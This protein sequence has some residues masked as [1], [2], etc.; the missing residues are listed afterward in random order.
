MGCYAIGIGG[1]GARGVEALVHLCAAGLGPSKLFVLIV[2]PDQANGNVDRAKQVISRYTICREQLRQTRGPNGTNLF[3]TEIKYG[4]RDGQPILAWS[5]TFAEKT[6]SDYFRYNLLPPQLRDV[7]QLLYTKAELAM[8]LEWGFRGHCSVGAPVMARIERMLN[9]QPWSDLMK[10]MEQDI[11]AGESATV[12]TFASIFGATGASGFPTIGRIIHDQTRGWANNDRV[13][14][15]GCLLLPYFGFGAPPDDS[16]A[17]RELSAKSEHFLINAK[18]ALNHYAFDWANDAHA[19]YDSIYL[20]GDKKPDNEGRAFALG[21]SGQANPAHY[22]EL[23][24]GLAARHFFHEQGDEKVKLTATERHKYYAG[25]AGDTVVTWTDLPD[26][27]RKQFQERFIWFT[28]TAAAYLGFYY[29]MTSDQS[30][31]QRRDVNP[32][33][34]KNFAGNALTNGLELERQKVLKDYFLFL[35]QWTYEL[36]NHTGGRNVELLDAG[37]LNRARNRQFQFEDEDFGRLQKSVKPRI[38]NAYESLF[39]RMNGIAPVVV[40][41][42]TGRYLD[43]L[44]RS[45][46][47]FCVANYVMR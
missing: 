30:F 43:M 46:Q 21:G 38:R 36:H 40:D 24:G 35:M 37:R 19:P 11:G 41:S 26:H 20:L 14:L 22:V 3:G 4:V 34:A 2:D 17:Q 1:T 5:P 13:K 27:E 28:S 16:K 6:L 8:N 10:S 44:Y 42:S 18:A 33:Y 7:A 29:P 12:F 31:E 9:Q 23:L 25:R 45:V 32:W 39:S 15:G 47:E